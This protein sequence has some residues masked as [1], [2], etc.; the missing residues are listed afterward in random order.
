M[1]GQR[2]IRRCLDS[3]TV[4]KLRK[5]RVYRDNVARE[6]VETE[7]SYV[8]GLKTLVEV[9]SDNRDVLELWYLV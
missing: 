7:E 3:K 6:I 9:G 5:K 4:Q 2:L 1:L 8:N